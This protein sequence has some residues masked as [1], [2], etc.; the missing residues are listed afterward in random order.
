MTISSP[1]TV[2][3]A[4]LRFFRSLQ[5]HQG[6]IV[7]LFPILTGEVGELGKEEVDQRRFARAVSPYQALQPREA[8]HIAMRVVRLDQPDA[9]KEDALAPLKGDLLLLVFH[10]RHQAHGHPSRPKL[11]QISAGGKRRWAETRSMVR[12]VA[13]TSAAGMPLSVTSPTTRPRRPSSSS[14]RS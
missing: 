5:V 3:R 2:H 11:L 6:D 10:P 4:P 9:V 7:L 13:I 1:R 8:E 12:V 14:N